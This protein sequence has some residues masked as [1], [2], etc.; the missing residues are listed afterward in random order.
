MRSAY[1]R[2]AAG[3]IKVEATSRT[4]FSGVPG[5][6][7]HYDHPTCVKVHV[8]DLASPH[9]LQMPSSCISMTA[10][11]P[12]LVLLL[13]LAMMPVLHVQARP[14]HDLFF[15]Y[16]QGIPGSERGFFWDWWGADSTVSIV[17]RTPPLTFMARPASFGKDLENPLLGYVIPLDAFTKPCQNDSLS[18]TAPHPIDTP[19][20]LGCPALCL[21]GPH[22]PEP[23]ESWIALVQRGSCQFVEKAR[24]AQR[25]GAKAI[26]VGGDNPEIYGNPDTLVNMYSPQDASDIEIAA[27]YIRYSDYIHLYSLIATSNTSHAGLRTL[28]LLL[29]TD[30][31]AWE[32]YS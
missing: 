32:W 30:H 9:Y 22:E 20:N 18:F 8:K 14:M 7:Q 31:P 15:R 19:F 28:S 2:P 13:C 6:T 1:R 29:S 12:R 26:V 27:T 10:I 25:L 11:L 5:F 16:S 21:D 4:D 3:S 23:N 17:D 24:E